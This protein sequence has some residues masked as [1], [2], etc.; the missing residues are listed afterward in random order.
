LS[1][2]SRDGTQWLIDDV[3]ITDPVM[4]DAPIKVTQRFRRADG[5][6]LSEGSVLCLM[7]QWRQDLERRNQALA[8]ELPRAPAKEV[9]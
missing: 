5:A 9:R 2:A 4:Y 7:D 6:Q 8:D 1:L 3:T